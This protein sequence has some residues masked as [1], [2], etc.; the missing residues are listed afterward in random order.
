MSPISLFQSNL[1]FI[2]MFSSLNLRFV[3]SLKGVMNQVNVRQVSTSSKMFTFWSEIDTKFYKK[4]LEY[5]PKT[6]DF[7]SIAEGQHPPTYF[8]IS[9]ILHSLVFSIK[10]ENKTLTIVNNIYY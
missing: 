4:K 8:F 7:F 3:H 9:A 5:V 10:F 6:G 1:F 2:F